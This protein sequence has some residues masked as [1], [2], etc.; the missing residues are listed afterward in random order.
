MKN[1]VDTIK[2]RNQKG[3]GANGEEE[4]WM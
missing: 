1:A 4:Y 3:V 2:T